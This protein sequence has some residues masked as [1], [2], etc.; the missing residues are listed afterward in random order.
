[1]REND[2]IF[3]HVPT[4]WYIAGGMIVPRTDE[5]TTVASDD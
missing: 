1:M 5:R 3:N 4:G 2:S